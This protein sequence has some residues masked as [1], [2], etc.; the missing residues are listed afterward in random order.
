M[1]ICYGVS[2][3]LRF[4]L[5]HPADASEGTAA[6][7]S[8]LGE[9]LGSRAGVA[10]PVG[11]LNAY[12][13]VCT[14]SGRFY[15][16]QGIG[17]VLRAVLWAKGDSGFWHGSF[18]PVAARYSAMPRVGRVG[19]VR[20]R[21]LG[22]HPSS[23][24]SEPP[25]LTAARAGNPQECTQGPITRSCLDFRVHPRAHAQGPLASRCVWP[26]RFSHFAPPR[27]ARWTRRTRASDR[28]TVGRGSAFRASL[29]FVPL[30]VTIDRQTRRERGF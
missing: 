21:G 16:A 27:A 20:F 26:Q 24:K 23:A 14:I 30:A 4:D 18:R 17:N 8:H 28:K 5:P 7:V 1:I 10:K 22:A 6:S 15:G 11:L 29:G 12:F 3:L 13:R 2:Q 25:A 19:P 9:A